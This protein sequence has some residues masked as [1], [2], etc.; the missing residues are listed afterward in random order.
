MNALFV[1][2]SY[3]YCLG[4]SMFLLLL[5]LYNSY[6]QSLFLQLPL[7]SPSILKKIAP[8]HVR[9]INRFTLDCYKVLTLETPSKNA[10]FHLENLIISKITHHFFQV[11]YVFPLQAHA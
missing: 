2:Y 1:R 5:T 7:F 4:M 6:K 8:C 3:V 11:I 10:K 9:E